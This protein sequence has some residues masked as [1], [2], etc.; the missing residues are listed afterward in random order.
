MPHVRTL[1]ESVPEALEQAIT[2]ALAKAPADRFQTAAEFART[3]AV[4][5]LS[6]PAGVAVPTPGASPPPNEPL[7]LPCFSSAARGRSDL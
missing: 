2:R 3:L 5:A 4:P 6:P 7:N 1:R